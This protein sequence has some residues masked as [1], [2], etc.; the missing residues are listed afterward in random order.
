MNRSLTR[1]LLITLGTVAVLIASALMLAPSSAADEPLPA[2]AAGQ[3]NSITPQ[4]GCE[5]LQTLTY[6]RCGHQVVRRLTAPVELYGQSL[7]GAQALYQAWRITE[8]GA[9]Q[10]KMEQNLELFCPD[11]MVLMPDGAGMLCVFENKYGDALSM[12][13]ELNIPVKSLP[14]A[15]QEDVEHGLGFSTPEELEMWLESVES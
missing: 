4:E 11:H 8:F 15:A 2:E 12:V 10:I 14:A 9:K 3:S 7:E 6:S 13:N 5:L 1:P